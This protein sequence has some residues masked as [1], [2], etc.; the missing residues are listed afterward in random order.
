[1]RTPILLLALLCLLAEPARGQ[2]VIYDP[3]PANAAGR[4]FDLYWAEE[5]TKAQIQGG[6]GCEAELRREIAGRGAAVTEQIAWL[7]LVGGDPVA[8]R[9]V[10]SVRDWTA[11][12]RHLIEARQEELGALLE[13]LRLALE[14]QAAA[15]R[16]A[17]EAEQAREAAAI[18][19]EQARQAKV[20]IA[21]QPAPRRRTKADKP[22]ADAE[23]PRP[24]RRS[25]GVHCCDG[26]ESP[27]CT[28]VH[29][30]CC[31]HHGGVC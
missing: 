10:V 2:G 22:P 11:H 18:L 3:T 12:E 6:E 27:T 26:T 16:Q 8:A 17:R 19:A 28:Y 9:F 30:G 31:S 29:R 23:R 24:E 21:P 25:S 13:K 7:G 14:D 5:Y 4:D 20:V 15:A 1:M